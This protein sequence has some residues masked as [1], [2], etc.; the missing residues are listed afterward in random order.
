MAIDVIGYYFMINFRIFRNRDGSL[1]KLLSTQK[2]FLWTCGSGMSK[3]TS[4]DIPGADD[5]GRVRCSHLKIS[6]VCADLCCLIFHC[7]Q[8]LL[9]PKAETR[10]LAILSKSKIPLILTCSDKLFSVLMSSWL[11]SLRVLFNESPTTS[12]NWN[13]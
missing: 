5:N 9:R 2:T 6:T 4:L 13:I 8:K 10:D 11:S 3:Q 7:N 1:R 12:F